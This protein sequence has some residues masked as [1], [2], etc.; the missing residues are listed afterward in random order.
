MQNSGVAVQVIGIFTLIGAVIGGFLKL[1]S[2]GL[3]LLFSGIVAGILLICVG[4][5]FFA[6]GDIE[7]HAKRAADALDRIAKE[8]TGVASSLPPDAAKR[9]KQLGK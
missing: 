2:G 8:Q 6:L 4:N 3:I 5:A 7:R 9:L 1:N